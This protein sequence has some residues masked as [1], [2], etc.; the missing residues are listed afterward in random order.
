M[1]HLHQTEENEKS[2]F[3]DVFLIESLI[4]RCA[5]APALETR[6]EAAMQL[7]QELT[8]ENESDYDESTADNTDNAGNNDD[9]IGEEDNGLFTFLTKTLTVGHK[10]K[11]S[12]GQGITNR[13]YS[14]YIIHFHIIFCCDTLKF[15]DPLCVKYE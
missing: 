8:L 1:H 12:P 13:E 3:D 6:H 9:N 11:K 4:S 10:I 7:L 15:S 5:S 2:L 14:N